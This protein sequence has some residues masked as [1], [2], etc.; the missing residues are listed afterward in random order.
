MRV[1]VS[2]V[3]QVITVILAVSRAPDSPSHHIFGCEQRLIYTP[4]G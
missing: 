4:T 3:S 1:W 2:E